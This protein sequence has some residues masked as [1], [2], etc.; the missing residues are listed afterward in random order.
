MAQTTSFSLYFIQQIDTAICFTALKFLQILLPVRLVFLHG[1]RQTDCPQSRIHPLYIMVLSSTVGPISLTLKLY[2]LD[3]SRSSG[4]LSYVRSRSETSWNVSFQYRS[5][6]FFP[7]HT[8][9]I[10]APDLVISEF[11]FSLP[12]SGLALFIQPFCKG[13]VSDFITCRYF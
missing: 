12:L 5:D 4:I 1:S 10:Q 9:L 7:D 11:L 2:P 8:D 13:D 6:R 3:N